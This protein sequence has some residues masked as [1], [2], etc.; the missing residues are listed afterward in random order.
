MTG[1]GVFK[2]GNRVPTEI[3]DQ[4]RQLFGDEPGFFSDE[5]ARNW[6]EYVAQR[7]PEAGRDSMCIKAYQLLDLLD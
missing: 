6:G 2:L 1:E 3:T 7:L 5:V 4:R